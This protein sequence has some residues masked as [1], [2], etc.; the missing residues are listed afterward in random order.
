MSDAYAAMHVCVQSSDSPSHALP[1]PPPHGSHREDDVD[2]IYKVSIREWGV[3]WRCSCN[4]H[5]MSD[6]VSFDDTPP[7]DA[8]IRVTYRFMHSQVLFPFTF[9]EIST[10]AGC[11][12]P[13][14]TEYYGSVLQPGSTELMIVMELLACS[15]AD[16]VGVTSTL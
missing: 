16:L 3:A 9:Q 2:D 10:L 13:N 11:H 12:C 8:R 15:V 14:I 1:I 4:C 5:A 7:C 6:M